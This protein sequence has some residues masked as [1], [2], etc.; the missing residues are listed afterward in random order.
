M[1]F[2]WEE[3]ADTIEAQDIREKPSRGTM[4]A[5]VYPAESFNKSKT[6]TVK[7][8]HG[9]S[10]KKPKLLSVKE[11]QAAAKLPECNEI[12][13]LGNEVRPPLYFSAL[14]SHTIS[15]AVETNA[16]VPSPSLSHGSFHFLRVHRD[17]RRYLQRSAPFAA[18]CRVRIVIS[19]ETDDRA[20]IAT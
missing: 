12:A 1:V 4:L 16:D 2:S 9:R 5:C 17:S 8:R 13:K 19:R 10:R 15:G 18:R 6:V 20:S 14:P 11:K 7:L 3:P